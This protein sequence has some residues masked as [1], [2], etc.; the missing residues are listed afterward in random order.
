MYETCLIKTTVDKLNDK[1]V[2]KLNY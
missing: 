1:T 2:Q